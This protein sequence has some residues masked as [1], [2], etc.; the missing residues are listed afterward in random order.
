MKRSSPAFIFVFVAFLLSAVLLDGPGATSAAGQHGFSV[1][2]YEEFHDVLHPLEHEALPKK[3]FKRIRS[4]ASLLVKRGNAIVKLGVP[5]GTSENKKEEFAKELDSFRKALAKFRS[6]A[7]QGT[8]DQL[9]TS[10]SA[11]HDSFEMLA[12]LLR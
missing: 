10:Y 8:N 1:K 7:K 5:S 4:Q 9:K 12:A 2:E 11:V 6:D 3:D